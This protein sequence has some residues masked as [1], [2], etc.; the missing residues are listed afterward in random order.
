[1][2]TYVKL[3]KGATKI[4]MAPPKSKY[5]DPILLGSTTPQDFHEI[6]DGLLRRVQ[7]SAWTVVFKSLIVFHLLARDGEKNAAF[8]FMG[9]DYRIDEFF[10]LNPTISSSSGGSD[11]RLLLN[12][13]EYL[14]CRCIEFN[15]IEKDFVRDDYKSLK[16][17]IDQNHSTK[18][19]LDQVE[20]LEHQIETLVKIK[21]SQ[22]DLSNELIF[23]A[24]KLLIYDLLPLY[25]ALNE[26]IIT[27]LEAFFELSHREAERTL[28]LYKSFVKLTD[29]VV[30]YLKTAKNIGLRIPVIKHITT[31]L[32]KSLEDHL[33]ED[34]RTHNTFNPT[35]SSGNSKEQ[36]FTEKRLQEIRQ[37]KEL[38][39]RQLTEQHILVP[40]STNATTTT[41]Q[42]YNPFTQ[43][44][45][46]TQQV[47]NNPFMTQQIAT[48][49]PNIQNSL[50]QVVTQPVFQQEQTQLPVQRVSTQPVSQQVTTQPAFQPVQTQQTFQQTPAQATTQATFQQPQPLQQVATMPVLSQQVQVQPQQATTSNNYMMGIPQQQQQFPPHHAATMSS[51]PTL[52]EQQ[53]MT[54][55][56]NNPFALN[57]VANEVEKR[58]EINPFS[59]RNYSDVEQLNVNNSVSH[60]PFSLGNQPPQPQVQPPQQVNP[61]QTTQVTNQQ[62]TQIQPQSLTQQYTQPLSQPMTQQFTQPQP[63]QQQYTQQFNQQQ[64]QIQQQQQLYP[65]GYNSLN[66]IDM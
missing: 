17:V 42:M 41:E 30:K 38:L 21:F 8:K 63:V 9:P 5:I 27:L 16:I 43:P 39:E 62:F 13:G 35:S 44:T 64:G 3:V 48:Q 23:Y 15:N 26:G 37:Q 32:V 46:L 2:T 36:S 61:F 19:A 54:T 28:Q 6:M 47:T 12:Y 58:Q 59:Q 14:K 18:N 24:F 4:K 33:A 22:F 31:K 65:Q 50:Q 11:V 57:N 10:N 60:N 53:P 55:G 45:T 29:I 56:S 52:E 49:Q 25:N 34:N 1:M 40:S 20:S 7:D 66:L 51:L